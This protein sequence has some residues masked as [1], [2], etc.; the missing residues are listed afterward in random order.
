[1]RLGV[2]SRL[3]NVFKFY[4]WEIGE[5]KWEVYKGIDVVLVVF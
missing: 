4:F 2:I 3:K 1:M 5:G